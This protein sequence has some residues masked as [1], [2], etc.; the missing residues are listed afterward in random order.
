MPI[1]RIRESYSNITQEFRGRRPATAGCRLVPAPSRLYALTLK[2]H[3]P[4]SRLTAVLFTTRALIDGKLG[5]FAHWHQEVRGRDAAASSDPG[6]KLWA[7]SDKSLES[8]HVLRDTTPN[9]G[10]NSECVL[11]MLEYCAR[12]G[13]SLFNLSCFGLLF[14]Q[15]ERIRASNAAL[16]PSY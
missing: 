7:A 15:L 16:L 5:L 2:Q 10:K 11:Q 13:L 14:A 8:I 12:L 9:W 6:H 3:T 1:P 4:R